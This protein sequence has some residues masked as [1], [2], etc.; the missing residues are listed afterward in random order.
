MDLLTTDIRQLYRKYLFASLGSALAT[1]IYA[2]VD[3]IAVGQ[4]VGPMGT[5][6][7]AVLNPFFSIMIF[8][9]I[10]CGIGGAVLMAH[11]KGEGM[12]ERGNAYFTAA[13]V[14]MLALT[15]LMW[16]VSFFFHEPIFCFFGATDENMPYV[17]AY[18]RWLVMA[19]P[20]YVV[21]VFLGA[22][23]RN[24]GAPELAMLAVII[25]GVWNCFG[26]WYFCFPLDMGMAGAAIATVS[27][28]GLQ[29]LIMLT[30]FL[31]R[32]HC[33]LRLVWPTHLLRDLR[34]IV[35]VGFGA[36]MLDLGN[37]FIAIV[38]N[39]QILRYGNGDYLAVYGV[40]G[41]ISLLFQALFNGVS[42]G[43][44]PLIS[45]NYGARQLGRVH[46]VLRMALATVAVLGVVFMLIGECF[47]VPITRLFVAATPEVLE[48]A[49]LAFHCYFFFFLFLGINILATYYLQSCMHERAAMTVSVLRS[50]VF[51][52]TML[53][54]LPMAFGLP[55]VFLAM[56]VSE[57]IVAVVSLVLIRHYSRLEN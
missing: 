29:G 50:L 14:L 18:G 1:S 54:L 55:G 34:R 9:A 46:S 35:T 25:G 15:V 3:T 47:P 13:L 44:Q 2:F 30:H 19:F 23:L 36:G 49:P 27:G 48:A 20:A 43:S 5:A 21:P 41:T 16:V 37:I 4:A 53:T 56:P 10:I 28:A 42:Q 7:I 11:A 40:V 24:D 45:M 22:Y 38:I 12:E 39:N 57:A 6:A 33:K 32:K 52:I 51:S 8:I 17:L 26:D 31:R